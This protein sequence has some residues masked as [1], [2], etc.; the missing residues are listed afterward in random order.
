MENEPSPVVRPVDT[1]IGP[2]RTRAEYRW[3]AVG[4]GISDFIAILAAFG[5]SYLIRF[6]FSPSGFDFL[7]VVVLAPP[8]WL[9]VF[10]GFRLYSLARLAPAEEVRRL[11]SGVTVGI[12]GIVG[13]SYWTKAE[14][15]RVWIAGSWALAVIFL[16][17]SRRVWRFVAARSRARGML[18]FRTLILGTNAE[19]AHLAQVIRSGGT[20]FEAVGFIRVDPDDRRSGD[21]AT[22]DL[23][24]LGGLADIRQVIAST[25]A[26]CVYV[27]SSAVGAGDLRTVT[28][29]ARRSAVEIRVSANIPAM[30]SSRLAAQPLGGLMGF[31]LWP[32]RLSGAQAFVKRSF[33]VVLAAGCLVLV[34]PVFFVTA[35][36]VKVSSPGPILYRQ[37][38]LGRG[39]KPFRL[40]KFRTMVV[41]ADSMHDMVRTSNE[42]AAPLFKIRD[43][44]RVTRVGRSL[45][46]WS[47][48]ELP[49]L[50][51][52]IRGHMSL[53]GPRPPLAREVAAYEGWHLDRLEVRPGMTGLWQ[54][55]GRSELS[56]DDYVR[57]DLYYIENWSLAYD[58]YLLAKTLPAVLSG[59]GAS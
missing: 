14:L 15:S 2:P 52:V 6:G 57:L 5:V 36:A 27:A 29:L 47:L 1:P 32:V 40:L 51:N 48:D 54:V 56:F 41:G 58:V 33:D 50:V 18:T 12:S 45:R 49:Q 42:A 43:D 9:V 7:A 4:V 11:V 8:L 16:L 26:D 28:R 30:L 59:R 46:R 34:S 22:I 13:V 20:G 55:S 21:I 10:A 19:A 3:L 24:V 35:I 31:S 25:E 44:P 53:V 17:L 37:D 23:P 39:Q 38:R